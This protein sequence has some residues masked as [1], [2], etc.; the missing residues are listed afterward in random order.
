MAE[1]MIGK[2]ALWKVLKILI[3]GHNGV[4]EFSVREMARAAKI[5][6]STAKSCLDYLYGSNMLKKKV[7]GNVYQYSLEM[8]N[9]AARQ[10][11]NAYIVG[12]ILEQGPEPETYLC[13]D[14]KDTVIV[15]S[16]KQISVTGVRTITAKK[17][18][19]E[20]IK[21]RYLDIIKVR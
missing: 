1:G 18:E 17:D 15:V 12:M 13:S 16:G 20:K 5:G 21:Q 14:E 2:Y 7:I 8:S 9:A 6:P 11:K 10:V 4:K 19:L 3:T